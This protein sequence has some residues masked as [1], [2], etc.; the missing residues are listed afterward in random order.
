MYVVEKEAMVT[1]EEGSF[2]IIINNKN[3]RRRLILLLLPTKSF[4]EYVLYRGRCSVY[5]H[6]YV[7]ICAVSAVCI[8][9]FV[10]RLVYEKPK[11]KTNNWK[12]VHTLV[13]DDLRKRG[14][15]EIV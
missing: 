6:T 13:I 7:H 9:D 4:R 1:Q 12:K 2:V 5:I 14:I 10:L 15:S 11:N 3:K 8:C